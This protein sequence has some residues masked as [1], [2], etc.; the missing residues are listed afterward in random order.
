MPGVGKRSLV[1]TVQLARAPGAAVGDADAVAGQPASGGSP[2]PD[3]VR[4]KMERSFGADFS[5]VSV[6]QDGRAGAMGAQAYAQ[7]DHLHFGPG[8]YDTSSHAGQALIGHELSHVVQQRE[9]R[10]SVPQGKGAA[11]VADAGLEAEADRHGELAA[12]GLPIGSS[13][14]PSVSGGAAIQKKGPTDPPAP[15]EPPAGKTAQAHT[16]TVP[17]ITP[18][19]PIP[20]AVNRNQ[21][22]NQTYHQL[23]TAMT[24]YL[25]EPL[26]ANWYTYGQHASREAGTEI[27]ALQMGL[28]MLRE[29]VP[30]LSGLTF[31]NPISAFNSARIAVRMFRRILD[32]MN[33]D[34]LMRQ[35]MQLAMAKAGISEAE[36]SGLVSEAETV[37]IEAPTATLNPFAMYHM[38]R[39]IAHVTGMVA[40]LIVAIPAIIAAVEKVYENM[41]RGNRE[42][43]ENVAP[44]GHNFLQAALSAPNGVPGA[45]AFVG[46]TNGFLAAAFADYGEIRRL[47]DEARAAPG[48][49]EAATKLAQRHDKAMHANLLVGYQEQLVILQP[50]FNTMMQELT[51]MSGTMVLHDPNGVHPLANNWG[52]FYTRMGIDPARA[53]ADP[54]TITPGSL[55]PLLPAAQRHGTISEYFNDNVDN[56]RIHQAPPPIA[57]G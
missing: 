38:V 31:G 16:F 35:A 56:E 48:T 40:K 7:G 20:D 51:A 33:T 49:P 37:L 6:H 43:Y 54:R 55:P 11:V 53:P 26:V 32:L 46:D 39:F 22:I 13:S 4:G 19:G 5:G 12:Q 3:A 25:G 14:A 27:R 44:A 8:Q 10:A 1:E 41:K 42:I 57:P 28:Q 36:L 21:V 15:A 47:G 52:D 9:G 24:G 18:L 29:I 34:G 50:I 23:D 2:L 17:A 30:M 45:M